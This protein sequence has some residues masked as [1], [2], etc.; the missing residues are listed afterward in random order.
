[1]SNGYKHYAGLTGSKIKTVGSDA[2]IYQYTNLETCIAA[3][4]PN[5]V[6]IIDDGTYSLTATNTINYNLTMIGRGTVTVNCGT[7][8]LANRGFM[9]N[10][11]AAGTANT[12]ITF[13]N[14]SFANAHAS[15]DMFEIDNDGGA[16]GDMKVV[17]KNCSI[18]VGASA[19]AI[20]LDQTTASINSYL[21]IYGRKGLTLESCNFA[22]TKAASH[23]YIDGYD[24]SGSASTFTLGSSDVA[25]VYQFSNCIFGSAAIT[26]GGAASIIVNAINC[27]NETSNEVRALAYSDFDHTG[28]E[29]I[30]GG[31]SFDTPVTLLVGASGSTYSYTSVATAVTAA[32]AGDVVYLEPGS[33]TIATDTT[34][35]LDKNISIIGKGDCTVTG[36]VADRL[37]MINKPSTGSSATT[38][39]LE[40]IK[41]NNDNATA[42]VIELDNDGGGTGALTFEAIDCGFDA[43]A[44][45]LSL[46]IDQT[47]NTIDTYVRVVSRLGLRRVME[48]C[49]FDLTKAASE[50]VIEGYDFGASVIA[51]GTTNVASV[52]T[53]INCQY[54]SAAM[55]TGGAAS[56]IFNAQ[57]CAKVAS[58]AITACL[59]SDFDA[60]AASE[61]IQAGTIAV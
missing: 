27:Q 44:S 32:N 61:N 13:E 1:M 36:D 23:V 10:K 48:G 26:T 47:T 35:T 14:I 22:L 17:F 40:N 57:G 29:N 28:N 3:A 46:D 5:D 54:E 15:G 21:E 8:G 52:Y 53:L 34:L 59:I 20:D 38:I 50:V 37:I 2:D 7:A 42:D 16:T 60:T 18:D 4:Q 6:I 45:G 41:F 33:H 25:S 43:G 49:N 31:T 51:L 30:I 9:L 19:V 11:P 55:T 56:I 24:M 58:S 12:L 39:R